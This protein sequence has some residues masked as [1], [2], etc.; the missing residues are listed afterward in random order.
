VRAAGGSGG[1]AEVLRAPDERLRV[2]GYT[3][4]AVHI[5]VRVA[6][7]AEPG[8]VLVSS[9]VKDLVAGSGIRFEDRGAH[10]LKGI[11]REW[12]LRRR[13]LSRCD[14]DFGTQGFI[15]CRVGRCSTRHH[16]PLR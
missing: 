7:Q 4:L 3:G 16:P 2:N 10:E 6:A 11:P 12:P 9:T 1:G 14:A 8:E 5:G 13:P 15:A